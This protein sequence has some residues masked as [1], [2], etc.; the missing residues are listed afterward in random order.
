[1]PA[2]LIGSSTITPCADVVS[3]VARF[4]IAVTLLIPISVGL[5]APTILNSGFI[6]S[7]SAVAGK[8]PIAR[9]ELSPYAFWTL[10]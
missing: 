5:T 2:T 3:I 10:M 1:M 6:T 9:P 8:S 7:K 4:P